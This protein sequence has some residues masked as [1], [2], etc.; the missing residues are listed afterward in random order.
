MACEAQIDRPPALVFG[1]FCPPPSLDQRHGHVYSPII[2]TGLFPSLQLSG[3]GRLFPE[4]SL[5]VFV[6]RGLE[7]LWTVSVYPAGCTVY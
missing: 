7:I 5:I 4:R 6:V 3:V 2:Q 1:E